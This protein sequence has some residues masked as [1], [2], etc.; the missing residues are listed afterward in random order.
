MSEFLSEFHCD[1]ITRVHLNITLEVE[2]RPA[3][4]TILYELHE[5]IEG[6]TV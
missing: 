6:S 5:I 3:Y 2:V 1:I 4:S